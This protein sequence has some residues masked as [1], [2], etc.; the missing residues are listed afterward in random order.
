MEEDIK[1][2][3]KTWVHLLYHEEFEGSDVVWQARIYN[4]ASQ[5]KCLHET[6]F[7]M[8]AMQSIGDASKWAIENGLV[9][10]WN[11]YTG[12]FPKGKAFYEDKEK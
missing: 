7:K 9:P 2:T 10:F 8:T 1:K 12:R 3:K 6:E 4:F 5:E 11:V